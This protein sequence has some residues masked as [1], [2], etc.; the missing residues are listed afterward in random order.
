MDFRKLSEEE[1]IKELKQLNE[2]MG[3]FKKTVI[4]LT[5]A[6][7]PDV[8]PDPSLDHVGGYDHTF[9]AKKFVREELGKDGKDRAWLESSI[10]IPYNDDSYFEPT[11]LSGYGARLLVLEG[12]GPRGFVIEMERQSI[13]ITHPFHPKIRVF[14]LY[15]N[16]RESRDG[17]TNVGKRRSKVPPKLRYFIFKRDKFKCVRCGRTSNDGFPLEID[18]VIP[19]SKG[20]S[21]DQV[22]LQTLC[23]ECNLGKSNSTDR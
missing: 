18:H 4:P 22:N 2:H 11:D 6:G 15:A 7:E 16:S 20:G 12:T 1:Q 19:V 3:P 23:S 9:E 14:G 21:N 17:F 5:K 13:G 8:D 10:V